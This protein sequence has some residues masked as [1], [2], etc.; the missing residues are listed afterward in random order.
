MATKPARARRTIAQIVLAAHFWAPLAPAFAQTVPEI[1]DEPLYTYSGVQANL[2]LT[3]DNSGSM[4]WQFAPMYTSSNK[5]KKCFTS[6]LY[7][8]LYFDPAETYTPPIKSD[9]SRYPD[10]NFTSAWLDGFRTSEGTRNLSTQFPAANNYGDTALGSASRSA[11]YHVYS[12]SGTPAEGTCYS[13]ANYTLVDVNAASSTVKQNF[14][15]WFSY[16]RT[17][18]YALKT[19]VGEAFRVVD[20][21]FRVGIH[22]INNPSSTGTSGG[23]LAL[24]TFNQAQRDAFYT[25]LYRQ[26]PSGNTPLREAQQRIG[27]YYRTGANPAG[28][29]AV[30]DP[31]QFT[32][33][34]NYH[35]LSTDGQWNASGA[36]GS[37]GSTN[38]DNTLP[39]NPDLL[40]A[41]AAQFGTSF[42]AG[43]PW[44]RP[45]R[46]NPSQS[47]TN[48]LSDLAA[49]YWMTDLRPSMTNNVFTSTANPANWQ[50]MV[51]YGLA[52]SEQGTISYPSGLSAIIAGTANWPKP[53]SDQPSTIDDLWHA[54]LIGH[55]QFFS[56]SSPKEMMVALASAISDIQARQ[57]SNSGSVLT[58]SD[59]AVGTPI[60]FRAQYKSGEWT[61]DLQARSVDPV[62]GVISGAAVWKSQEKLDAQVLP[63][64]SGGGWSTNRMIVTRSDSSISGAPVRFREPGFSGTGGALSSTQHATLDP[65]PA[66]ATQ[67]LQYLRGDRANEDTAFEIKEFRRRPFV[68]GDIVNSEPRYV[69]A[70]VEPYSDAYHAG[71]ASFRSAQ[72]SREPM[73][74]V[75]ANDG[76]LHAIK[77]TVGDADSGAEKWAY[78]PS[79][80]FRSGVTGLGAM[81]W[82]TSDPVPNKFSHRFRVDQTPTV[83]DIDI[84][85]VRGAAGSAQWRTLLVGGLNKGGKGYYA[86]DVTSPLAASEDDLRSKVLWEFD[87]SQTGDTTR[88]G[89]SFGPPMV[90]FTNYGWVVAVTSG[91]QNATGTGHIWLL[92][93]RDG[94]VI[95]R[96]DVPD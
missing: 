54:A 64:G 12:G 23:F 49:Y 37:V 63:S 5:T 78:V 41:L 72:L 35:L 71:Y 8:Q 55:G 28:S 38:Y 89:Y 15:N 26:Q 46:E 58:G 56:V 17:R 39:N 73:V 50:H 1:T 32:C 42:S 16:Y 88:L 45:Y 60:A 70:P 6:T 21:A 4:D 30:P 7:N 48:T 87:A 44:P 19:S 29:G 11:Y 53:S 43:S 82:R 62:T 14:A 22:T 93:P 86:L 92:D 52:F 34:Q 61:G 85:R 2:M 66:R 80:M 81:S 77:G 84:S 75:G 9:G 57:G 33:Q 67:I 36:S 51:T 95:K 83:R 24:N 74:Y 20:E 27:E 79:F 3:V 90:M 59:F 13:D 76:M 96:L 10:S 40:N 65:V 91:Y 47:S 94:A 31:I 69:A 18:M 25:V 68:L